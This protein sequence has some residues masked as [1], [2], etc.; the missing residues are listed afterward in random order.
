MK[1]IK[2]MEIK[3]VKF[4]SKEEFFDEVSKVSNYCDQALV[5]EVYYGMVKIMGRQLREKG[6]VRMPDWGD[7][8]L[9]YHA[10][11]RFRSVNGEIGMLGMKKLLK[12]DADYKVK[13]YFKDV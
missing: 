10:P 3:K 2:C 4:L 9:R 8:E 13:A 11:R 7:F 12:F 1:N 6:K 5:R